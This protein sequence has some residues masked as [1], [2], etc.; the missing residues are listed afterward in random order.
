MGI[1]RFLIGID[2]VFTE[3]INH[4]V[5]QLR[6]GKGVDFSIQG[7]GYNDQKGYIHYQASVF[8]DKK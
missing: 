1:K 3:T 6:Y 7:G 5:E 4:W 2:H 8:V